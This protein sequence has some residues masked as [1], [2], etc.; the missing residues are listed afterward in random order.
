VIGRGRKASDR[1]AGDGNVY[2]SK[3]SAAGPGTPYIRNML[4]MF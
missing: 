2:R 4:L 1:E 3:L